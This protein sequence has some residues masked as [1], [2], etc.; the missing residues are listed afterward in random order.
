MG[1]IIY[2]MNHKIALF[3][4]SNANLEQTVEAKCTKNHVFA[5]SQQEEQQQKKAPSSVEFYEFRR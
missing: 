5:L 4:K 2:E 3:D 1:A